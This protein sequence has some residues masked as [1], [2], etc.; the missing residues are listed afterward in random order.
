MGFSWSAFLKDGKLPKVELVFQPTPK[1]ALQGVGVTKNQ[2]AGQHL[3]QCRREG[4]G[5]HEGRRELVVEGGAAAA[6]RLGG[7]DLLRTRKRR[8]PSSASRAISRP[9]RSTSYDTACGRGLTDQV[10]AG[11]VRC[12]APTRST[13][14]RRRR[15]TERRCRTSSCTRK[16]IKLDGSNPTLV[17]GYGGFQ[18]SQ[19]P[20]YSGTVGKLWLEQGGV[21]VMANIRGGGEFGPA[22]HQA[23]LKTKRQVVYDDFIAVCRGSDRAQ[24]HVA[25]KSSARW[26]DRMAACLWA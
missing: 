13:S 24:D 17:Y 2:R 22:W 26:A 1:Q 19:T 11:V 12:I 20:N 6:Q 8:R 23:G 4:D 16:D 15:R 18:V 10:A 7:R 21:Y 14:M 25:R 3:R 5:L 9:M